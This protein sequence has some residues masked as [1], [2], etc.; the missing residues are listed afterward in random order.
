MAT[1]R[2]YAVLFKLQASLGADFSRT[3]S[4]ATAAT[5]ALQSTMSSLNS[6]SA[7][8][9][10]FQKQTTALETQKTKLSQL[11]TE[12]ERLRQE[13]EENGDENGNLQAQMERTERQ[14]DQTTERIQAQETR[15]GNLGDEL[16]AAGVDTNDLV[17][18]NARLSASYDDLRQSQERL[19][20]ISQAQQKNN[21]AIA[22]TQSQ[23][24]TAVGVTAA[25]GATAVA[26]MI[27]PTMAF[28]DEMA[29]VGTL[30]DGTM[31]EISAK[32]G[33]LG[34]E[35]VALSSAMGIDTS[36]VTDGLY[37]VISAYGET[38]ES[39]AQLEVAS[40][41][42]VAG[43]ANTTDAVN[44]LSAVTK[45][46]GDTS[47][48][49]Q[50]KAADL[51]FQTVKLGQTSFPE[52]ASAMG[53]V[54]PTAVAMGVSQEELFGSMATL[55]GV[56]GAASEVTTQLNGVL[57]GFLSPSADMTAQIEA[58]GYANGA[59]MIESLGL[60][61]SLETLKT[62][63]DN[64]TLA[65]GNLFGSSEA[66]T[67]IFAMVG[68][69]SEN[70]TEKTLAM[71]NA[72][73]AATEAFNIMNSTDMAEWERTKQTFQNIGIVLG[74]T[75]LP[76]ITPVIQKVSELVTK[77]SD[78]AAANPETV[79]QIAEIS[80]KLAA[81]YIAGLTV[82]LGL[83]Q[84]YGGFLAVKKAV[85]LAKLGVTAFSNIAGIASKGF[86]AFKTVLGV[87]KTAIMAVNS[88][89][90][91]NPI[92]AVIA[93]IIG[94]VVLV[95]THLEETRAIIEKVFG[96][97]AAAVFD[98]IVNAV[99][100]VG[101]VI[102][103]VFSGDVE[104]ARAIMENTFGASGVAIFDSFIS[105]FDSVKQV[106]TSVFD[107]P[108]EVGSVLIPAFQEI[109]TVVFEVLTSIGSV[110]A[111][112]FSVVIPI[113]V[114]VVSAVFA[115]FTSVVLPLLAEAFSWIA[116]SVQVWAG[117]FTAVLG[118]AFDIVKNYVSTG[119]EVFNGLITFITG[120]FTGNWSQ[121]WE[122]VSSIF[123][124]IW[125]G[126][127]TM[128]SSVMNTIIG[129]INAV[130]KGLNGIA[131]PD[132]VPGVG[133]MSLDIPTIPQF[134]K[135]TNFTPDTFIAGEQGA[136]LITGAAGRKVFTAAQTGDIFN[137]LG[138]AQQMAE[139]IQSTSNIQEL[140]SIVAVSPQLVRAMEAVQKSK[141]QALGDMDD[142]PPPP[143]PPP[144]L[145]G[146][147]GVEGN[148]NSS[149]SIVINSNPVFNVGSGGEANARELE[150]MF[151]QYVELLREEIYRELAS[152][153]M[154]AK[155]R[156]YD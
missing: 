131:I 146:G 48:E 80:A 29:M 152:A 40:K 76:A 149:I 13:M 14:I 121:A 36:D 102:K 143:P 79:R 99:K 139:N 5:K 2:E 58:L 150:A 18:E 28:N 138:K 106:L 20:T 1:Q 96:P 69:Q 37:Q 43:N 83:Q 67:A 44:L 155:R 47:V 107:V 78:W 110:F 17:G 68:E 63:V 151:A 60:Q 104:S 81:L 94:A 11:Q 77:F 134:A 24:T 118:G 105:I 55:T 117:I 142:D 133:G 7:K 21:E 39:M 9:E 127:K 56:T 62:A 6:T 53:S 75:L 27:A 90:L 91:A 22:K 113:A 35:A 73:G 126:I 130:I 46:Y 72:T 12:Y 148:D 156:A 101:E 128:C 145:T 31:E 89:V 19:A 71:S 4:S 140:T 32:T 153:Q 147:G 132:W 61:G 85:E 93:L 50:Q 52:L 41:A 49:A 129:A 141:S 123:S 45:G 59:A 70:L 64:D 25:A 57:Q 137:N 109:F 114:E 23:L 125:N 38:S 33:Q 82:K 103:S 34:K 65:L 54:I 136:E 144:T 16:R 97:E 84:L 66:Q 100:S 108:K 8:I 115:V 51:A 120:V 122:G 3:M 124:S 98:V 74:Q 30:L 42:A 87:A 26:T 154:D 88:A 119:I 86:T 116:N 10:G 15:L 95:C 135:G 111:E 92:V 112:I